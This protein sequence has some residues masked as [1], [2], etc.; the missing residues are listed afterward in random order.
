MNWVDLWGGVGLL[1]IIPFVLA[2]YGGHVA[3]ETISDVR[4]RRRVKLTFWVMSLI[5]VGIAVVYQFRITK[6]DDEKQKVAQQWQEGI[7][8]KL[9]KIIE[10]PE[11][12]EQQRAAV[13]LKGEVARMPNVFSFPIIV[14]FHVS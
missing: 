10:N 3:A 5:G 1:A 8:T 7:T 9:D 13:E 6:S 11:S 14:E 2:A 12:K 4:Q